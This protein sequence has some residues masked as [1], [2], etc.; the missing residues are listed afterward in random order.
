MVTGK[1]LEVGHLVGVI[2]ANG[3]LA[4]I[5]KNTGVLSGQ[6]HT[7]INSDVPIYEGEYVITPKPFDDQTLETTGKQMIND[8]VV[9]EIPYYETSNISGITIYI[10]G[11]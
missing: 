5:I 4:G 9:R 10:G 11:E 8:V 7:Y 2:K 3:S 6:V 1:I